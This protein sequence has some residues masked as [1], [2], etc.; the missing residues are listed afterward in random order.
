M[1]QFWFT[2]GLI[3]G[4]LPLRFFNDGRGASTKWG[5]ST[6]APILGDNLFSNFPPTRTAARAGAPTRARSR[7]PSKK[8]RRE[9]KR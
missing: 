7:V 9:R 6:V 2:G 4:F 3:P 1:C 5:N 8:S